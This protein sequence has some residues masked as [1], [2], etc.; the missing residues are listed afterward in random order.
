MPETNPGE[1]RNQFVLTRNALDI[2]A[3][4]PV[5]QIGK[6]ILGAHRQLPVVRVE[7][8]QSVEIGWILGW[9]IDISSQ[10]VL[11]HD[12]TY[13][14]SGADNRLYEFGGRWLA[15]LADRGKV[16]PDATGSLASVFMADQNLLASTTGL[17]PKGTDNARHKKMVD[18]L[19]IPKENRWYPFALTAHAAAHRLLPNHCLDLADFRQR[20]IWPSSGTSTDDV[21]HAVSTIISVGRAQVDAIAKQFNLKGNLTA[22]RD[23]RMM[24]ALARAHANEITLYTRRSSSYGD[25]VDCLTATKIASS[26]NLNIKII[27]ERTATSEQLQAWQERIGECVAGAVW[28]SVA[29]WKQS[30]PNRANIPGMVGGIGRALYKSRKSVQ[31][32]SGDDICAMLKMPRLDLI[33]EAANKWLDQVRSVDGISQRQLLDLL[34]LEQ[35]VGC[36]GAPIFYGNEDHVPSFWLVSHR[37]IIESIF[38]LPEHYKHSKNLQRDVIQNTWPELLEFPFNKPSGLVKF[39]LYF[40]G[41]QRKIGATIRRMRRSIKKY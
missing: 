21:S 1:W 6:W 27:E 14:L 9:P 23:T 3:A 17:L 40:L 33:V 26:L 29:T 20:R 5:R 28:R 25:R 36:W 22:G 39:S 7:S 31:Q 35:R 38:R 2:P 8:K 30:D 10:R 16:Y 24:L 19:Q 11:Q 4:W 34:Y 13:E 37:A 18:A 41:I 15:I 12:E 32:L